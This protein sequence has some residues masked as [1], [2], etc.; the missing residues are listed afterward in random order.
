MTGNNLVTRLMT[1]GPAMNMALIDAAERFWLR[2]GDSAQVLRDL[3][4]LK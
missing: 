3:G 4:L 1:I 2:E